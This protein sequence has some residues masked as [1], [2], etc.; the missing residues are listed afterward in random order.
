MYVSVIIPHYNDLDALDICLSTL[1]RQN[2][3]SEQMEIIV[4]DNASPQGRASVEEVVGNRAR[5]I[6]VKNRGAGPARNG[7]VAA[8][9]GQILAF[10][11]ADCSADPDWLAQGV[12]ALTKY[13]IV[14]GRVD[15]S[16]KD[17]NRMTAAEAFE[18]VFAF[19]IENY[20]SRKGFVVTANL[21]CHRAVF[22]AVGDFGVGVSE[23][24]D[25]CHRAS[26]CNFR[27]GYVPFALVSHR[28]RRSWIELKNK[29]SRINSETYSLKMRGKNGRVSWILTSVIL[30]ASAFAHTPRV[31]MS[32]RLQMTQKIAALG[33][34]YKIR[35][36][37]TWDYLRL[38]LNDS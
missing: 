26:A 20:L 12:A 18:R 13:D 32:E 4:A 8:S 19:D 1:V 6:H 29:W 21:F 25:W 28:A 35:F 37:R 15:V 34:L 24:V 3:P 22:D 5:L 27:I 30:P 33:M 31:L 36:W 9:T 23:D 7:G 2:F 16:V 11:D 38:L 10:I 14:G 17:D